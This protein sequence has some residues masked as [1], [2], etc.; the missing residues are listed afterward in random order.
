MA[1][2]W[3]MIE[4]KDDFSCF[5]TEAN[6]S[7]KHSKSVFFQFLLFLRW[8]VNE[9]AEYLAPLQVAPQGICSICQTLGMPPGHGGHCALVPSFDENA[10]KNDRKSKFREKSIV[11]SKCKYYWEP[12]SQTWLQFLLR[13]TCLK[14]CQPPIQAENSDNSFSK[15]NSTTCREPPNLRRSK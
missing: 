10:T 14:F 15:Q 3:H 7:M 11:Q 13:R 4:T 1:F 6:F 5:C 9:I 12:V 8:I 2:Y